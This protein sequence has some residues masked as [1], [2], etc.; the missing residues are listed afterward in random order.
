MKLAEGLIRKADLVKKIAKVKEELMGNLVVPE[1]KSDV[2]YDDDAKTPEIFELEQKIKEINNQLKENMLYMTSPEK[3]IEMGLKEEYQTIGIPLMR[4]KEALSEEL[5]EKL[6]T[7]SAIKTTSVL[8]EEYEQLNIELKEL[9]SKISR[10]NALTEI[11]GE[12]LSEVLAQRQWLAVR[13][14]TYQSIL[15]KAKKE[16]FGKEESSYGRGRA[17]EGIRT[18]NLRSLEKTIDSLSQQL[19]YLDV[20]IQRMNWEV[21][22]ED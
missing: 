5:K 1:M 17:K 7:L 22:L 4:Q 13:V 6:S 20:K 14:D 19:R 16:Y 8:F 15:V 18:V 9:V 11:D 10:S 21:D 2:L 3:I 12:L